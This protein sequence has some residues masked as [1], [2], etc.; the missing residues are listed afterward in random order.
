M[1]KKKTPAQQLKK[2]LKDWAKLTKKVI[3]YNEAKNG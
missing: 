2:I 3:A 1:K